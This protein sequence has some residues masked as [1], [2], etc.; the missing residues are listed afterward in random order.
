M[1]IY[2]GDRTIDGLQVTVDGAPLDP[3][4]ALK[5]FSENGFEW[6]YE[7]IEPTQLAFA[8]LADHLGN[9]DKA[10]SLADGFMRGIVANFGNEWELTAEDMNEAVTSLSD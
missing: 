1:K 4:M 10:A 7:G 5:T 3:A 6:G 8:L 2:H 9:T